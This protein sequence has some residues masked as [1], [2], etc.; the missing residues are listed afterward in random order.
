MN[1]QTSRLDGLSEGDVSTIIAMAWQD[2][3]PFEA[4]AAQFGLKE[5][6]VLELMRSSLKPRSFRVWRMRVRGRVAKH[7]SLQTQAQ[8]EKISAGSNSQALSDGQEPFP[9][10]P[11][12]LSRES[13]R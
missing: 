7:Q 13:L 12:T 5:S 11:S 8:R 6:A 3:T 9:L 2:D 4:I 10:P 1:P